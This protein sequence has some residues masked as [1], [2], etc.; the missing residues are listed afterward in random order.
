MLS[1]EG[2]ANEDL[3]TSAILY[4]MFKRRTTLKTVK[5]SS[6]RAFNE[7]TR[8]LY[9]LRAL[10]ILSSSCSYSYVLE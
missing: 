1:L 3:S 10:L 7:S 4:K 8:D 6:S 5:Y 2:T 9:L